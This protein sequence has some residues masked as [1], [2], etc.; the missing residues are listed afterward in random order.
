MLHIFKAFFFLRICW[1]AAIKPKHCIQDGNQTIKS[2][3]DEIIIQCLFH[4]RETFSLLWTGRRSL[5]AGEMLKH[6]PNYMQ[7][8]VTGEVHDM[9]EGED[10][11]LVSPYLTHECTL[12]TPLIWADNVSLV[13][14][15]HP[16]LRRNINVKYTLPWLHGVQKQI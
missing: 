3:K 12:F 13:P 9:K 10:R 11:Q 14:S 6:K 16:I 5:M 2:L 15:A 1:K 8:R 4:T 7:Y